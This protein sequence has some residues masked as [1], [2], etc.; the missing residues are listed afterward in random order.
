MEGILQPILF[1]AIPGVASINPVHTDCENSDDDNHTKNKQNG[2]ASSKSGKKEFNGNNNN[3]KDS[4]HDSSVE[5]KQENGICSKEDVPVSC[6]YLFIYL[7]VA[8][9]WKLFYMTIPTINKKVFPS[10]GAVEYTNYS[11]SPTGP[12]LAVGG[13]L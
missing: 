8:M 9:C 6:F 1:D 12:L 4:G 13:N 10:V 5:V 7:F 2:M 11:F 3:R